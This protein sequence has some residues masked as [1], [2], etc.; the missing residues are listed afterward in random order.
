MPPQ[1]PIVQVGME[2]GILLPEAVRS[3]IDP[4]GRGWVDSVLTDTGAPRIF[5]ILPEMIPGQISR[6]G[7][8]LFIR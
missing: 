7:Y 3:R 1:Y 6:C 2:L 5:P 8:G 4:Y